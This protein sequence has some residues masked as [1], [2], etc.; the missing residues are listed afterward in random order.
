MVLR[1]E[2]IVTAYED[3]KHKLINALHT[4]SPPTYTAIV[5]LVIE[6]TD[7]ND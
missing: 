3:Y 7:N 1:F 4:H 2:V 6:T 5:I